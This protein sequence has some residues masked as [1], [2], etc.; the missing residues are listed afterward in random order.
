MDWSK[1]FTSRVLVFGCGNIL[2]GDDAAGPKVVEMLEQDPEIPS[3]VGL[4]DVG[5]SIRTLLFDLIHAPTPPKRVIVVDATTQEGKKPGEFWEIDVDEMDPKRVN[6]FS[7]HMF[8]TVNL[9]KDLKLNT[10]M[11]VRI[12]VVQTGFIPDEIEEG[13]SP[14]MEAA[15]PRVAAKVKE[16]CLSA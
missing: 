8:P 4:L 16:L 1:M 15:L 12:V 5:T 2:I 7:L 3:D 13:L 14:E 11:E 10:G 9:L 6:D